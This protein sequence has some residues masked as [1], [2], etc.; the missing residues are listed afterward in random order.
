[1]KRKIIAMLTVDDDTAFEKCND[2]PMTYLENEMK[3]LHK[4]KIVLKDA[5]ISDEDEPDTWKQYI[6]YLAN[7]AF[8][9]EEED[10]SNE[11]PLTYHDFCNLDTDLSESDED[12]Y[13]RVQL[14]YAIEDAKNHCEDLGFMELANNKDALKEIAQNFLDDY[15][16]NI[17]ENSQYESIIQ[18]KEFSRKNK[19]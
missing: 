10:E 11:S 4:D 9:Y 17:A 2:G 1:M 19:N 18:L 16:C 12:I 5:F 13:R 15:D 6:N 7:W 3:K 14:Q 8:V